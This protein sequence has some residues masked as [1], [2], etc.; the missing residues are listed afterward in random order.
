MSVTI[1]E[2]QARVYQYAKARGAEWF[3]TQDLSSDANI[4]AN[5]AKTHAAR[6]EEI[7]IFERIRISPSHA[8]RLDVD[9]AK[10]AP[11][12]VM[13]LEEAVQIFAARRAEWLRRE[14]QAMAKLSGEPSWPGKT[15]TQSFHADAQPRE[16]EELLPSITPGVV[17]RRPGENMPPTG[18]AAAVLHDHDAPRETS[19]PP[20]TAQATQ[21][22]GARVDKTKLLFDM[23]R[24][25]E[26]ATLDELASAL[27]N[28]PHS[29][30]ASISVKSR[31][32]GIKVECE[33]G[34]YFIAE[35]A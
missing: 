6:F 20:D 15:P 10:H 13:R 21:P 32:L 23:I 14:Q 12:L 28:L 5:T 3:T 30:R 2:L 33:G 22:N 1:S 31:E 8:F 19:P 18:A 4:P 24:R 11:K 26:G 7:G 27:G 16:Y 29:V 35:V 9:A 25:P 17:D 34:R